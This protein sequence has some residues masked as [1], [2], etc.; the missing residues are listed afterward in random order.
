MFIL[1]QHTSQYFSKYFVYKVSKENDDQSWESETKQK[2]CNEKV[3]LTS[4]L[5]AHF[6]DNTLLVIKIST[7]GFHSVLLS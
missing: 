4:A 3:C 6:T 7:L 2:S 5:A 1:F